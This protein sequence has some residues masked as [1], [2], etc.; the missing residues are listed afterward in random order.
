VPEAAA[1]GQ[2][3]RLAAGE[4]GMA[5]AAWLFAEQAA[6]TQGDAAVRALRDAL[7]RSWPVLDAVCAGWLDGARPA[8]A[9]TAPLQ[10]LLQG[11]ARVVV[12][13]LEAHW[14]DALVVALPSD[15]RVALVQA[16]ALDTDWA[17]VA[18]NYGGRVT[19]LRLA[20]FQSWAGPRS[21][22]LTF[23]YG[24]SGGQVFVLPSWLRVAGA[25]VRL[26][27]RALLGWRV[28]QVPLAVYPRWL[29]AADAETFTG[30]VP[31]TP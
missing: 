18:A 23:A 28:L 13:G 6:A 25:D 2:A 12:V 30:L 9:D 22:L 8:P 15:T 7:G 1:V 4:L 17:R 21:V 20:D 29:V 19:L 27:F 10:P 26:Q 11:A 14:L 24:R 31:D 5:S 3:F 16:S